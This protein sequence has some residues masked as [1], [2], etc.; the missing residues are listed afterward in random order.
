M[1][2]S[3]INILRKAVEN[4][5]LERSHSPV[6]SF[7]PSSLGCQQLSSSCKQQ[8]LGTTPDVQNLMSQAKKE[9]FNSCTAC[10]LTKFPKSVQDFIEEKARICKPDHIHICDGSENEYMAFLEMLR[11]KGS[12]QKLDGMKNCWLALTDPNDVARVESRTFICTRRQIDTIPT[13]AAGFKDADPSLNLRGLKCSSLGNWMSPEDLEYELSRRLPGCM[14]GRTMYVIPYSM[15]PIGGP[16]SKVGIELTDSPYVACSMR[17]MTRMGMN[18]LEK[19][20]D[21]S[22]FVKCLHTVG[23]PLPTNRQV[24]NNWPCNPD[25]KSVV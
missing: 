5:S 20:S 2:S 21:E 19:I 17:I 11:E 1:R 4:A 10:N 22:V 15:G 7:T 14:K 13:P 12:I 18:V 25:R 3:S 24:V 8:L 6:C 9:I 16:I 23:V